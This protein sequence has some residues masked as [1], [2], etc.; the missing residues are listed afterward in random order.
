MV[1]QMLNNWYSALWMLRGCERPQPWGPAGCHGSAGWGVS[2]SR[3]PLPPTRPRPALARV[4]EAGAQEL[5]Q[6]GGLGDI[7]G[8][9]RQGLGSREE[10]GRG[11]IRVGLFSCFYGNMSMF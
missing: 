3:V 2:A 4:R 10:G 5:W 1:F 6:A 7:Q 9:P 8:S 11:E